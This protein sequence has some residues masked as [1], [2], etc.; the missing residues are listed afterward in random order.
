MTVFEHTL[1]YRPPNINVA[2]KTVV[3]VSRGRV[4]QR[5]DSIGAGR[6]VKTRV[7]LLQEVA[8]LHP[9]FTLLTMQVAVRDILLRFRVGDGR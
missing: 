4:V 3:V 1:Q 5:S 2:T 8:P 7:L 9:L 6:G